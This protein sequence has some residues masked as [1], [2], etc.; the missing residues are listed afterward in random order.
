MYGFDGRLFACENDAEILSRISKKNGYNY[1]MLLTQDATR[2]NITSLLD[3][4]ADK[5]EAGDKLLITYSGH[6]SQIKSSPNDFE[7]EPDNMDETWC[8]YDGQFVDNELAH[9]FSKF[10]SGVCILLI[11]DSCHSGTI[12]KDFSKGSRFLPQELLNN[13]SCRKVI[14]ISKDE[15]T[16]AASLKTFA[17]CQDNQLSY[18]ENGQGIFTKNLFDAWEEEEAHWEVTTTDEYLKL[19]KKIVKR[20]PE[21]QSPAYTQDG[22][23][24]NKLFNL[25]KPF[26]I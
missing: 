22:Q 4:F 8:L 13:A 7:P 21:N 18:E 17:G 1:E 10:K 23:R 11:S 25:T 14:P 2:H 19:F 5:L 9:Q 12:A 20:M 16:I 6:G 15:R 26:T 24:N 3:D